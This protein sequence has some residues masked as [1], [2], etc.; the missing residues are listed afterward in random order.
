VVEVFIKNHREIPQVE[1]EASTVAFRPYIVVTLNGQRSGHI[2]WFPYSPHFCLAAMQRRKAICKA[3][4]LLTQIPLD[5]LGVK[6]TSQRDAIN[7]TASRLP[8]LYAPSD[9]PVLDRKHSTRTH[10][11]LQDRERELWRVL[12][13][14]ISSDTVKHD[15]SFLNQAVRWKNYGLDDRGSIPD[16]AVLSFATTTSGSHPAFYPVVT[17][18]L[19]SVAKRPGREANHSHEYSAVV[20][21]G[22]IYT[23]TPLD[24][25]GT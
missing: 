23:S 17:G 10:M 22:W 5:V 8:S 3:L 2:L 6:E 13:S 11:P 14:V 16:R 4:F 7:L 15:W 9:V 19:S 21:N 1:F 20:K 18:V 25:C 24:V 12:S